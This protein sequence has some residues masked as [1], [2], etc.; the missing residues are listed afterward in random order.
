[1][2]A[3][4]DVNE[5]IFFVGV[6]GVVDRKVVEGA[7]DLFEIPGVFEFDG[8]SADCGF[9]RDGLDVIGD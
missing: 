1:M 5:V 2:C 9:G 3:C 7:V 4:S 8:L 6:E